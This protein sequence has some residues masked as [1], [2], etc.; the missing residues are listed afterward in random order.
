MLDYLALPLIGFSLL[1]AA[2][3]AIFFGILIFRR[4]KK[5]RLVERRKALLPVITRSYLRRVNGMPENPTEVLKISATIR[6]HALSHLHLLLRGGERDYLMQVAELDGLLEA[7]LR[8]SKSIIS[9]KRIQAVRLMQQFGSEACI[10]RLRRMMTSDRNAQVRL[11]AAFALG[12]LFALPPPRETIRILKLSQRRPQRLD[13]ALFRSMAPKYHKHL[14]D[15]LDQLTDLGVSI[16]AVDALGWSETHSVLPNLTALT[17]HHDAEIR[18]AALRGLANLGSSQVAECVLQ[19][20]NDETS[21]VRVQAIN[22]ASALMIGKA[23]PEL[24][25]LLEDSDLWVRLRAQHALGV[26]CG[27]WPNRES[28]GEV[29]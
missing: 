13:R 12:A 6:L 8:L 24:E 22:A 25:R 28:F 11:E 17:K 21:F 7:V 19:S 27:S 4:W 2:G 26:L 16:L 20:L 14:T 3:M 15:I 23:V 18:S 1:S 9:S 5:D 29:A 10:A